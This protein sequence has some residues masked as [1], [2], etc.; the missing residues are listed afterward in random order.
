MV[1]VRLLGGLGNQLFQYSLGRNLAKKLDT[2][3]KMDITG[4]QT[5]YKLHKYSLWSLNIMEDIAS[6]GDLSLFTSGTGSVITK[7]KTRLKKGMNRYVY[8]KE[9]FF[10]YCKEVFD[11]SG[12]VLID[13]YWQ[14]EKYFSEIREIILA[15]CS[16]KTE[17][18]GLDKKYAGEMTACNS[19]SMHI[20][21]ADYVTDSGTSQIHGACSLEYYHRAVKFI[22]E[23]ISDPVFFIFSD[24]H[25]WVKDN[26]RLDYPVKYVDHNLADKNFEDLRLMNTCKHNI[27]ANS[28]F[29]WWGAWMNTNPEK[30][31]VSPVK[32]FNQLDVNTEDIYPQSWVKL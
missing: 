13:G 26:I 6:A 11:L 7:L 14:S 20:R 31:V 25:Q 9:P 4:F 2:D 18:D 1:V 19:I 23:K 17:A 15:E 32:W 12:N 29:S 24:D 5:F 30:I 3:L 8:F 16:V 22:S 27:I 10:H 28:S 21:R